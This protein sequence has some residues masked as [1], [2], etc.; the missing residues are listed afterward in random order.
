MSRSSPFP[1]RL[2]NYRGI[3]KPIGPLA[4]KKSAYK[5]WPESV[6]DASG[7]TCRTENG[8]RANWAK[9]PPVEK[10]SCSTAC[11]ARS[12]SHRLADKVALFQ[13][14]SLETI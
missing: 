13:R 8:M 4:L 11:G 10:S 6:M 9:Y 2:G 12:T 1:I 7:E 5:S 14:V 3:S